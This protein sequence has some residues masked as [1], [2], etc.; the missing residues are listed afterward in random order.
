MET[1][2]SPT[3][4]QPSL[5]DRLLRMYCWTVVLLAL[6]VLSTGPMYWRI[7][8]AYRL[9]ESDFLQRL[10]LPLVLLCEQSQFISDWFD[11]YIG[12]WIGL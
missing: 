9:D 5:R 3:P 6:Y 7:F 2:P 8:G 1:P 10:Y 12:L 11:W 4:R